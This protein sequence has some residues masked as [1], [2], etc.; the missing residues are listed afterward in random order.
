MLRTRHAAG[1]W[2]CVRGR[3]RLAKPQWCSYCHS[4]LVLEVRDFGTWLFTPPRAQLSYR[5]CSNKQQLGRAY[6]G[7]PVAAGGPGVA[8]GGEARARGSGLSLR[9]E[10]EEGRAERGEREGGGGRER[11]RNG[12]REEEREKEFVESERLPVPWRQTTTS[13]WV[14]PYLVCHTDVHV[15]PR[16]R[17]PPVWISFPTYQNT[18]LSCCGL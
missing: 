18:S 14:H 17:P 8:A 12:R 1:G 4:T 10:E 9:E 15:W 11:R 16:P 2:N 3:M 6:T 13:A 7:G 5:S